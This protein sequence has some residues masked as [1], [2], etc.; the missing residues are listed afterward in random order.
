MVSGLV[1]VTTKVPRSSTRRDSTKRI[2]GPTRTVIE[3]S[4]FGTSRTSATMPM[5]CWLYAPKRN[6]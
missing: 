1:T 4:R 2:T 5:L 3:S 6:A